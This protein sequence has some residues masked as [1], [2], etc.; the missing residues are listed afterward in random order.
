MTEQLS[1]FFPEVEDSGGKFGSQDNNDHQKIN[2]SPI[3]ELTDILSKIDK[4]DVP[5]QL[6]FS[7][8]GQNKKFENKV[9]LIGLPTDSIEFLEF[10][11]PEFCQ[12]I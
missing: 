9:K 7:E 12:E 6:E 1:R 3:P 5:K 8:G 2:E 4:G 11:Q 10:L